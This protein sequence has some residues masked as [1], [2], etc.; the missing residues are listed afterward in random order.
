VFDGKYDCAASGDGIEGRV[1]D[2]TVFCSKCG[3][4][5][6]SGV[7]F[8]PAC[9]QPALSTSSQPAE[10]AVTAASSSSGLPPGN[11]PAA[12][13]QAAPAAVAPTY[14]TSGVTYAGFW[15]RVVAYLIDGAITGIVFM[16][17]FIP[18]AVTTG[19]TAALSGVHAGEDPRDVSALLTGT[20]FLGII[21]MVAIA[22]LGAWIYHAKMESS[23]WQATVGKRVLRLRVTD[24]N[25]AR[26][27]FARASGRHFGK[28]IT[29]MIPLG[30]GFAL[31]GLTE[32]RQAIHDMLA[33]CLVL[34][35]I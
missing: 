1:I 7:A 11:Y 14:V 3:N 22:F 17:L 8:C 20:F 27:T 15:L 32:R 34:R 19:L 26:V 9:G 33:S 6:Q 28:L 2:V 10:S 25:G 4:Q 24:M 29:G 5:I 30:V 13:Y 23:S 12:T 35:D 18:F 16:A 31:A 21:S